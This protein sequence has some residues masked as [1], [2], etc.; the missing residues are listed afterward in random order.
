[1]AFEGLSERLENSFKKLRAKGK[2][3]EADVKE[4]MREVR[5][6][7]LEADVNYKVAKEFTNKVTERAI[8]DDVMENLTPGQMVIKIVNEEL[9]ELMGGTESRLSIAKHPPTVL[10][11][12]GLQGSGKTTH[13]GKLALKLKKDGH[14]PLLVACDVYRP[15]A[16]KQLQVVGSQI[17]VP[18]FEM[19]TINPVNIAEEAVKHAK[20]H[21]YDYVIIDTAGRL[22]IDEALM[23][24]L[25]NIR[26]TV[27]P[28]E[29]LL[30]IDA[31]TGQD[32]VNVA[33]SFN[34]SLG[35]DGV[36]LTKLDGDTRGGAALSVRAVT[37]K[38][39]KFVGTGEKLENLEVFHPAR[40]ASRILGMG[41]VLS[42]IEKAE[43]AL[44]E[45]KAAELE[46][47]LAKNKFDFNDLLDQFEQIER[48]GSLKD[49]IKMIPGIG[50][51]IKD[52]DIDERAFDR[53]RC[54]IYSMTKQERANPEIINPSRK[55]RIAAGSGTSIEDVNKLMTQFKQMQKMVKQ[56][57][58]R[59]GPK[60]SKKMRRLMQQN[61]E[62]AQKMM[63]Q[64]GGNNNPFG[65]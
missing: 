5:L 31:M 12:C 42:F 33:K 60:V 30:V 53:L 21:G 9:T 40:M 19:G 63:G 55:R 36:I 39:I 34:E 54:I 15:A 56:V 7:L 41:D 28:N 6:A 57:G 50:K 17:D 14:R 25:Q 37:G 47:K 43:M 11:M 24:E 10:M 35:I 65:F 32:A 18:V 1:M 61:P 27:H 48:M 49:T 52:E 23:E 45:K 38:P 22:H 29:I 3:T 58:G 51:Q 2:L 16:I 4:A 44:D 13:S 62:M 64:T 26:S 59:K 46:K 20:D 8:G